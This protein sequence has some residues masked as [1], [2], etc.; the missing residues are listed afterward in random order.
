MSHALAT[1]ICVAVLLCA[2]SCSALRAPGVAGVTRSNLFPTAAH[3]RT[4]AAHRCIMAT[5]RT[6]LPSP[7]PSPSS[8]GDPII[9]QK[10]I[11]KIVHN[12]WKQK[13]IFSNTMQALLLSVSL[14]LFY[15][16]S[17]QLAR[18]PPAATGP[19]LHATGP[20]PPARSRAPPARRRRRPPPARTPSARRR[21]T[22]ARRSPPQAPARQRR[23]PPTK[24]RHAVDA[25]S[26]TKGALTMKGMPPSQPFGDAWACNA[27]MPWHVMPG[28]LGCMPG[29][30]GM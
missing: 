18:T 6:V 1:S 15:F 4:R 24:P 7:P 5:W 11:R 25:A 30:L 3:P 12:F 26:P 20:S 21:P 10:S 13:Q 28:C 16:L 17:F 9:K 29:C 27:W 22:P 23:P 19:R 8:A 2:A 14:F